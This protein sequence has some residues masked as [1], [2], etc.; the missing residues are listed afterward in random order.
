MVILFIKIIQ[1][2]R[3]F[4]TF[5][6]IFLKKLKKKPENVA[7]SWREYYICIVDD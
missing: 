6:N 2:K 4:L 1:K 5:F 3:N 7:L